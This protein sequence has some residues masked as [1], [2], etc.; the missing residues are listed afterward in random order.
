M[1]ADNHWEITITRRDGFWPCKWEWSV[2]Y[3][4]HDL[5]NWQFFRRRGATFTKNRASKKV[6]KAR[7]SIEIDDLWI[8]D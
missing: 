8:Y 7:T 2:E 6:V 1:S 5:S 4:N 3:N